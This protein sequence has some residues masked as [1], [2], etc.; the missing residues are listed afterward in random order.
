MSTV[1]VPARPERRGIR[2]GL[3]AL[4]SAIIGPAWLVTGFV[5]VARSQG[6]PLTPEIGPQPY[7]I[8]RYIVIVAGYVGVPLLLILAIVLGILAIARNRRPGVIMGA[9]ALGVLVLFV[10]GIVI[11]VFAAFGAFSTA[12]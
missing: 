4:L 5:L 2:L 11:A 7:E 6:E 9:S 1:P 3:V 8:A 12:P 10:V